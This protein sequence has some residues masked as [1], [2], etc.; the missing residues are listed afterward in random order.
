MVAFNEAAIHDLAKLKIGYGEGYT[1]EQSVRSLTSMEFPSTVSHP[2]APLSATPFVDV[3]K[4]HPDKLGNGE[5]VLKAMGR[6]VTVREVGDA[7]GIDGWMVVC[8]CCCLATL[9]S[10]DVQR[11]E[12]LLKEYAAEFLLDTGFAASPRVYSSWLETEY[13]SWKGFLP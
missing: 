10:K 8:Y 9:T 3:L 4:V 5:K 1:A 6:G 2:T 11:G 7:Y 13:K 12:A